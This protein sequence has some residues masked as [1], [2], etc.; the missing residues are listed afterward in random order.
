MSDSKEENGFKPCGWCGSDHIV[1]QKKA[2]IEHRKE[3]KNISKACEAA[4]VKRNS[5]YAW[6]RYDENFKSECEGV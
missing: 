4:G 6:L 2:F 3:G 1:D 5:Y